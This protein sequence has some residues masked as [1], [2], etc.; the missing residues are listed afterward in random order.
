MAALTQGIGLL[1]GKNYTIIN[2][3]V[4]KID[5]FHSYL[6]LKARK[7]MSINACLPQVKENYI[8]PH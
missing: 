1:I 4:E 8:K 5:S 2:G 6:Y 3:H 7:L